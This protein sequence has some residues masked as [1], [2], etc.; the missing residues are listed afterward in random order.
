[1]G[2]R[3]DF[4]SS[5][6]MPFL[7]KRPFGA[8]IYATIGTCRLHASQRLGCIATNRHYNPNR[9][10]FLFCGFYAFLSSTIENFCKSLN[11]LKTLTL[12]P[13]N[14]SRC[15]QPVDK[16]GKSLTVLHRKQC[17]PPL[18][19]IVPRVNTAHP[20]CRTLMRRHGVIG[21]PNYLGCR[22]EVG[23]IWTCLEISAPRARSGLSMTGQSLRL[24]AQGR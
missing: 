17:L 5:S 21:S 14:P 9:H 2:R 10:H 24:T 3:G 23:N 1:M 16:L 15:G 11:Q 19:E 13:N 20:H 4:A 22:F 18:F 12:Q 7:R 8:E 6:E